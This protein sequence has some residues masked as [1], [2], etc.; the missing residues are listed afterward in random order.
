MLQNRFTSLVVLLVVS[1]LLL[2]ACA[3]AAAP[4]TQAPAAEP[5]TS[6]PAAEP[7]TAAPAAEPVQI[8]MWD[9]PESEPYT[10]WWE[11]YVAAFNQANPDIQ[12]KLEVF[13]TEPYKTKLIG[14][15]D[16]GTT[17]DIFYQIAAGDSFKTFD[18]GKALA[19]DGLLDTDKFTE[20]GLAN[21]RHNGKIVCMPLY[22]APNFWF[23]NKAMF[24][25]AGVDV[26]QWGDPMQPTWDE[27]LAACDALKAA[28]IT[29]IALGN[30]DAWPGL[31]IYA[32]IQNRLGG[33]E[34]F[35]A[36]MNGEGQYSAP[37]FIKAGQLVQLLDERGYFPE[38]YNGISGEQKYAVFTQE[39]GAMIF[40]G[41]WM[42]GYI[43]DGMP[44]DAQIGLFAFPKFPDGK[45][46]AQTDVQGGADALWVSSNSKH[47]EAAVK[48][49][50]GF[51]DPKTALSFM[52]DTQN[53]SVIKGVLEGA[54]SD[55]LVPQMV[56]LVNQAAHVAPWWDATLPAPVT[57]ELLNNM[58]ALFAREIT[59][60][61][62]V[63][64]LQA[65]AGR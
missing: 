22:F 13:E 32:S 3:P 19:L 52:N 51:T 27:F 6:A 34:E 58:Q 2:G 56:G 4:A 43:K 55:G 39:Q 30:G 11:N 54:P 10:Q 15:L 36:A 9:I 18:N 65:A 7:A 41:P 16:S 62:F 46:D 5:A 24:E 35:Y 50:N 1:V 17:A 60:E 33:N 38:G 53:I 14:A 64:L 25:K 29:P 44:A 20:A 49:L 28:G 31:T 12:V 8:T 61:A 40:Q 21:C 42:L 59:P 23:Y 26:K 45:P 57:E 63:A 48:F 47:P 37:S